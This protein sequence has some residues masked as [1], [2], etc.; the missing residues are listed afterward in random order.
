MAASPAGVPRM[1]A[2]VAAFS[3]KLAGV[4]LPDESPGLAIPRFWVNVAVAAV[5]VSD[6]LRFVRCLQVVL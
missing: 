4:L 5:A 1:L 6:V 2:N 3:M